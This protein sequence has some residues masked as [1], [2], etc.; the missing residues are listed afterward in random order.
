MHQRKLL[1]LKQQELP[2]PEKEA[3]ML[4]RRQERQKEEEKAA[5]GG[6]DLY[7]P[8]FLDVHP[9]NRKLVKMEEGARIDELESRFRARIRQQKLDNARIL[10]DNVPRVGNLVLDPIKKHVRKRLLRQRALITKGLEEF[11][12]KNTAQILYEHLGG[13]Q[14]SISRIWGER[15]KS[16]QNIYYHLLSD[17]DPEWVRRQLNIAT[18]KIRSQFALKVNMGMTPNFR[19]V[20]HPFSKE[21]KRAHLWPRARAIIQETPLGGG[22][23]SDIPKTLP[24]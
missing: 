2:N 1:W 18:P 24:S 6:G 14:V 23:G 12:T 5:A 13:V 16:T 22:H 20:P 19:F 8:A 21:V 15:P 7:P 17:H 9:G 11:L 3:K 4:F 10:K